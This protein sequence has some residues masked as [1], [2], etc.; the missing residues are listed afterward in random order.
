M[1]SDACDFLHE[2]ESPRTFYDLRSRQGHHF[3]RVWNLSYHHTRHPSKQIIKQPNKQKT[4]QRTKQHVQF[5]VPFGYI[6]EKKRPWRV[7]GKPNFD[8]RG[9]K[10]GYS[11]PPWATFWFRL[12]KTTKKQLWG[13]P[14]M[15]QKMTKRAYNCKLDFCCVF[16][17]VPEADFKNFRWFQNTSG[18]QFSQCFHTICR[19][20]WKWWNLDFVRPYSVFITFWGMWPF[21]KA[22]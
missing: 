11:R 8:V 10:K 2:V 19:F 3:H 20:H 12:Q 17:R 6:V 7:P 14:K 5:V 16:W 21:Q 4:N 15:T 13:D 9:R 1:F 22:P 18:E